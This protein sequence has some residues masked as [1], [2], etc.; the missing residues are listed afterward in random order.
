M[1]KTMSD[2]MGCFGVANDDNIK[3]VGVLISMG[4]FPKP[5]I[6]INEHANFGPKAVYYCSTY[7]DNLEHKYAKGI[8]I[9][10]WAS[11][12]TFKEIEDTLI[13]V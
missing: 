4:G 13:K 7:D 9:I 11:G 2:L 10:G 3:Y 12:N 5:E 1:K 8:K 6:I